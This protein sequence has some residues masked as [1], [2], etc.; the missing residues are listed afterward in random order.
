MKGNRKHPWWP[1]GKKKK[2]LPTNAG[3]TGSLP[4]ARRFHMPRGNLAP[5]QLLKFACSRAKVL[6]PEKALQW[7]AMA[8]QLEGS[9]KG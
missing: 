9:N 6:Q 5:E 7:E 4:G 8:Q 1:G 2:N 3:N